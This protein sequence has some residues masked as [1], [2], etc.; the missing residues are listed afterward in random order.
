MAS[1]EEIVKHHDF[2]PAGFEVLIVQPPRLIE[3][4]DPD[5]DW[6]AAF[7]ALAAR[8]RA[9]LGTAAFDVDHV[10]STS[11]PGLPAKP[12]IDIDISVAD[13]A[14][15]SAYRPQLEAAGFALMLREPAWHEH[16][17][18][19]PADGAQRANVH[20]FSAGCAEIVRHRLLRDWLIDHAD[21]RDAYAAAKRQ[22]SAVINAEGGGTGM[23]Y[24]AVKEPFIRDLLDRVFRANGLL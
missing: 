15:E 22:A 17:V 23:D 21:D 9:A 4:V 18:F 11:V 24:N 7:E 12:I 5:P 8:I 19:I 3:V 10:G 20:V 16:R 14:D 2:D 6:P 13:S 1:P